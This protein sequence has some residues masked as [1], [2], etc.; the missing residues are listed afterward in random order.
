M[1][2][3]RGIAE[4]SPF[5]W[6]KPNDRGTY[7]EGV[8]R[9]RAGS[10]T[11]EYKIVVYLRGGPMTWITRAESKRHALRYAQARWPGNDVE[12]L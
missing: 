3:F 5:A 4:L 2:E 9:P 12:L 6:D 10:R 11:R 8:S 1:T 7:G